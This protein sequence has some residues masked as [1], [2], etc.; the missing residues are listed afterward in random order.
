M[1]SKKGMMAVF[2]LC[3]L[4]GCVGD[5][6]VERYSETRSM[7]STVIS[8]DVCREDDDAARLEV[9]YQEAWTRLEDIS[10]R[11]NVFN[12]KSD[13][14]NINAAYKEPVLVGQ[15]TFDVIEASLLYATLTSGAFDITVWPLITLWRKSEQRGMLPSETEL[16]EAINLVGARHIRLVPPQS[17][18]LLMDGVKVDLGGIAKGYAIDEVARIFRRHGIH[19]FYIDAGGDVYVGGKKCADRPWRIGIRDPRDPQHLTDVVEVEDAAVATSGD[20]ERYYQIEGRTYSHIIDP[21]TGYP[22]PHVISVSMI[23]PTALAADALATALTV[24]GPEEGTALVERL[25]GAYASMIMTQASDGK[26][27]KTTSSTYTNYSP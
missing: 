13:V 21:R 18:Q 26:I 25:P 9:A 5:S 27:E 12:N 11:M 3:F 1:L 16:D 14:S 7:M 4:Q 2:G 24:L 15:D 8:L 23:A 20:Y 17:V 19:R 10:R 6:S 22:Q